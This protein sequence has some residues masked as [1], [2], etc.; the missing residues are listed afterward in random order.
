ML[1][2]LRAMGVAVPL[3][4]ALALGVAGCSDAGGASP[5][6]SAASASDEA[7]SPGATDDPCAQPGEFGRCAVSGFPDRPYQVY[8]PSTADLATPSPV[9]LMFH[10]GS[11]NAT[12]AI[13]STCP[14]DAA[15]A[16]DLVAA[17]CLHRVAESEGF[18][19]AYPNGTGSSAQPDSRTF[20]AGGGSDGWQCVG[21]EACSDGVDEEAYATAVLDDLSSWASIDEGAIFAAGLSNGGA[22]AHRLACTLSPRIAAIASVAGGNQY[23]TTAG[24]DP[25]TPVA[26]L[27]IHGDADP[28]WSYVEG[29]ASC[30][31]GD[32]G[33]KIG[34][35]ESASGWADRNGCAAGPATA[36][37]P[38]VDG[39][40]RSTV[41][42]TW[43]GCQAEVVLLRLEG[44]GHAWPG[45]SQYAPV[46]AI[47]PV[48]RDWGSERIWAFFAQHRR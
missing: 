5:N 28:C 39:N 30:F 32:S 1:K 10:G 19:V 22:L 25:E 29:D 16:P 4:L 8:V 24:C 14:P 33:L 13:P 45:G 40:G 18:I 36:T 38:D 7:R 46:S 31:E 21:G 3:A 48:S 43:S 47:G 11:G 42:T 17:A 9:V 12:S 6:P 15:R 20:D 23:A 2:H 41:S 44:G 27:E 34:A 35:E 37:E 26:V